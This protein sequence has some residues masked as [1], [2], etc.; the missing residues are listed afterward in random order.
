MSKGKVIFKR[1]MVLLLA[2]STILGYVPTSVYAA[3]LNESTESTLDGESND[4]TILVGV[5]EQEESE[6]APEIVNDLEEEIAEEATEEIEE[7][8]EEEEAIEEEIVEEEII[9]EEIT[10]DAEEEI[11]EEELIE[12]NEEFFEDEEDIEEE[13]D[14]YLPTGYDDPNEYIDALIETYGDNIMENIEKTLKNPN[15]K[16]LENLL[17]QVTWSEYVSKLKGNP[18]GEDGNPVD[19]VIYEDDIGTLYTISVDKD[20]NKIIV[21]FVEEGITDDYEFPDLMSKKEVNNLIKKYGEDQLEIYEDVEYEPVYSKITVPEKSNEVWSSEIYYYEGENESFFLSNYYVKVGNKTYSTNDGTLKLNEDGDFYYTDKKGNA[22]IV[23]TYDYAE[24]GDPVL[25]S[26][27]LK[28]NKVKSLLEKY[29][30]IGGDLSCAG[31]E[32][33]ED[34]KEIT[35]YYVTLYGQPYYSIGDTW[36]DL[37]DVKYVPVEDDDETPGEEELPVVVKPIDEPVV[38]PVDDST[39]VEPIDDTEPVVSPVE[40]QQPIKEEKPSDEIV[41]NDKVDNHKVTKPISIPAANTETVSIDTSSSSEN[42]AIDKISSEEKI[43]NNSFNVGNMQPLFIRNLVE[44][45]MNNQL[46]LM[47]QAAAKNN[48]SALEIES[49]QIVLPENGGEYVAVMFDLKGIELPANS[50]IY[51]VCWNETDLDYVIEG[52]VLNGK[53]Y[54][55]DFIL[56]NV[57][58]VTIYIEY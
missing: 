20:T 9:D 5:P 40:E 55:A 56:R 26:E 6:P 38:N 32:W 51:A 46:L 18:V 41:I 2:T 36:E 28:A 1:V 14:S 15:Q 10:E 43:F 29:E 50:T 13:D 8:F 33:E 39:E 45:D 31:Y 54:L 21:S 22:V 49:R 25:K 27:P 24:D 48:K 4:L 47:N 58:N 37:R 3:E 30:G 23:P 57:T 42:V 11:V 16:N 17:A 52:R 19:F 34:Y 12:E 53:A 35:G 44:R 7:I